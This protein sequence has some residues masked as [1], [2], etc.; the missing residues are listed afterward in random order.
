MNFFAFAQDTWK[1]TK[2][3]TLNLGLRFSHQRDIIPAQNES[4]GLQTFLGVSFNR[5]VT[6]S[7]TPIKRTNVVP[8]AGLIYD[9]T[10]DG[11]TLFKASYSRYIQ[12]NVMQYFTKVNPNFIWDYVQLLNPDFTPIPNAYIAVD[13]PNPAQAGYGGV[14]LKSPYTD[15]FTVG[16][17]REIFTDWL[18]AFRYIRK[19]ERNLLEDA[20]ASQLDMNQLVNNG[21]LVWTNW[22]QV[23][24]V[25]PYD[26]QQKSFW[27]Q[28]QILPK[29]E[30]MI[31]APGAKRD[32]DGIEVIL[33]KRYSRG[34]S[35][36]ASYVYQNSRGLI[37]TDWFD[38]WTGSPY[39]DNPNS[40]INAVGKLALC[41]PHQLKLQGMVKGPWGINVSG[42]FRFFSG[43]RYTRQVTSAD[44]LAP[45]NQGVETIYAETR[46]D[47]GLPTQTILDLRLEKA[48]RY[49]RLTF[50]V[51]VDCFNLFNGNKATQVQVISSSSAIVFG[52]MVS[53][54]DPRIFRLGARI[55]F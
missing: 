19:M 26:G 52:Q 7:Y 47:R 14:G 49:Q 17:E 40:H 37:G 55:Q 29:N 20:N 11:K 53:I 38:N 22:T 33:N 45:L 48:F 21:Q 42:Y 23:N 16:L 18:L 6:S 27:S 15:E 24:F 50:G 32:F 36:M 10:G 2:R 13:F 30:Y 46:G 39:Y 1:P 31:N 51:F 35:L 25:D 41:R 9:L 8:R 5:S 12:A 3:L 43:Q 28:N 4:E 34:W 44:L 54:E